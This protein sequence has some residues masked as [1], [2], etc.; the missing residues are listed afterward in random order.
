MILEIDQVLLANEIDNGPRR[1][2]AKLYA[3]IDVET[4]RSCIITWS[5]INVVS[6]N[7]DFNITSVHYTYGIYSSSESKLI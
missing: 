6:H 1:I 3:L 7:F 2:R 5:P 4:P